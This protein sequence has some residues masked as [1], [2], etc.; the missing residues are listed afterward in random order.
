MRGS[1][2]SCTCSSLLPACSP[3]SFVG[4]WSCPATQQHI[5]AAATPRGRGVP[6]GLQPGA[7]GGDG[8]VVAQHA[9]H[10]LQRR[11]DVLRLFVPCLGRSH[12]FF[13]CPP[14]GLGG[15]MAIVGLCY[16][17][18]STAQLLSPPVAAML[19]PSILVPAFIGEPSFAVWLTVKGVNLARWREITERSGPAL[20]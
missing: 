1:A 4:D 8:A 13:R 14:E 6:E 16:L 12:L 10:R 7:T 17:T 3:N 20:L 15:L 2:A 9:W 11:D 19:F 5:Q 18:L